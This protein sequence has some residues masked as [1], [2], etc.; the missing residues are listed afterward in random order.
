AML[1]LE[2]ALIRWIG[3]E[4]RVFAYIQN[5]ILVAS[6]LGIGL[7]SRDARA[8]LR[9]LPAAIGLVFI[10][11]VIND[12]LRMNLSERV[13]NGLAGFETGS[14]WA[15]G[16]GPANLGAMALVFPLTLALLGAVVAV[17]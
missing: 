12:P 15:L 8:A 7:G 1:Y 6:F 9:V 5:G 16:A 11:L 2:L 17:F 3:T 14:I 13:S 4:I 10:A